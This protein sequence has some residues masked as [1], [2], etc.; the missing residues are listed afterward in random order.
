[1]RGAL[2]IAAGLEA[3]L[4]QSLSRPFGSVCDMNYAIYILSTGISDVVL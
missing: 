2:A 4:A 3:V 1:M